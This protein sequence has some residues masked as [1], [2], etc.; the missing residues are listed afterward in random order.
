MSIDA[1][2]S[3]MH[4]N[5]SA[6]VLRLVTRRGRVM[7]ADNRLVFPLSLPLRLPSTFTSHI[8]RR[9]AVGETLF[10]YRVRTLFVQIT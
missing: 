7:I 1:V 2:H 9:K 10:A 8:N 4:A 6:H 5:R 3:L